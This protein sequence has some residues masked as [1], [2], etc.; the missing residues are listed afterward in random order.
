MNKEQLIQLAKDVRANAYVPY[1]N[2]PVGA[3]LV[4]E[5]G[6]IY[7][8]TNV[9]NSS[10]GLTICAERN[11]IFKAVSEGERRF[12]TLVVVADTDKPCMPCGGC[13]QVI[14]EFGSEIKIIATNLSGQIKENTIAELLPDAFGPEDLNKN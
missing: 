9:E 11:A 14:R 13:R 8:G 5:S 3:V 7:T 4:T 6:K 2:F 12:T 10:Y 1:S